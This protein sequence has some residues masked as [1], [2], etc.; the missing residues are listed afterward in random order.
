MVSL[1][2]VVVVGIVLALGAKYRFDLASREVEQKRDRLYAQE[3]LADVSTRHAMH[4]EECRVGEARARAQGE[5]QAFYTQKAIQQQQARTELR[6]HRDQLSEELTKLTQEFST[7]I[8]DNQ[9]QAR[10]KAAGE[11]MDSIT[12]KNGRRYTDVMIVRVTDDGLEIRH[13]A[14]SSRIPARDLDEQME[15]RFQWAAAKP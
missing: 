5:E 15:L 7:R 12:C 9:L 13:S 11:K 14:G 4:S 3:E 1:M 10:G 2:L 8:D 6:A